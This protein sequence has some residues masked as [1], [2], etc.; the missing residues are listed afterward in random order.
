MQTMI[1]LTP[2]LRKL[3]QAAVV[4]QEGADKYGDTCETPES[5]DAYNEATTSLQAAALALD[6]P[7]AKTMLED[8][9]ERQ[10]GAAR[11]Y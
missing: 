9:P 6:A 4:Y 2:E 10:G 11:D 5:E 7:W 3:I 1:P 8:A